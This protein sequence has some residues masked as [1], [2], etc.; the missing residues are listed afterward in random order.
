MGVNGIYGLSG[1]GLDV[2]SMVKV[3]MMSKQNE[4]DKMQQTYT[5]NEWK[6][7]AY[8]DVY[9]KLQTYSTSTLSTFK[10]SSS[11]NARNATSSNSAISVTAT[12]AAPTMSHTITVNQ[13]ATNAYLTGTNALTDLS[14]T[15]DGA[16]SISFTLY[17]TME[18]PASVSFKGFEGA[19]LDSALM[20]DALLTTL[21]KT[22]TEFTPYDIEKITVSDGKVNFKITGIADEQ[23]GKSEKTIFYT[24]DAN[25]DTAL[26][27][28]VGTDA[29]TSEVKISY[30]ELATMFTEPGY[31]FDFNK[32]VSLLNKKMDGF[33]ASYSSA[34]N[35]SLT[36][37]NNQTGGT[38]YVDFI[39][40]GIGSK[41]IP[42]MYAAADS[43]TKATFSTDSTTQASGWTLS[44]TDTTQL[45]EGTTVTLNITDGTSYNDLANQINK[46]GTNI[47]AT[48]DSTNNKFSIYNKN[49]GADNIVGIDVGTDSA[50]A[51]L[52]NAMGLKQSFGTS[53]SENALNFSDTKTSAVYAGTNASVLIDGVEVTDA[54]NKITKNGVIYDITNVTQKTSATIGVTQDVDKIVDNVKSFVE[55]YNTLL[56][57]LYKMYNEQPNSSYKPLT[58]AQKNEMTD[59]QIEKW[60]KKAKSGMLYHDSTIRNIIDNMRDAIG[61]PIDSFKD[62]KYKNAYSIGISTTGIYGQL[63]LDED[64]LR[65]ALSDDPDAVYNVFAT[66]DSA[67]K[68]ASEVYRT[69]DGIAQRLGDIMTNSVKR[70]TNVAGTSADNSDDSTLSTLL[71]NLQSR[72]SSFRSMMDAFETKLYKKY[73]SM[74]S[75][76]AILGSQLNYVTSA[77][78]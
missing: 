10:M 18:T 6:K 41:I 69:N 36:F 22:P 28:G 45:K 32:F 60:E 51:K 5:Q 54:S 31:E 62:Y 25:T 56:S 76:L 67:K 37:T 64:K 73:D 42:K 24:K 78:A 63:T 33:T 2:E 15:V 27:F 59:E 34:D 16:E 61:S 68:D 57:D 12:A 65:S 13:T 9:D 17:D 39:Y 52:F 74:E 35:G 8:L 55:S 29:N 71:R 26:C 70:I 49:S 40:G 1:S 20:K 75:S 23:A 48:F 3:G 47:R 53:S 66:L 46:A 77:F 43:D 7:E 14:T 38:V 30:G 11:M 44:N 19:K 72:M 21:N 4:Y 50:A 58:D